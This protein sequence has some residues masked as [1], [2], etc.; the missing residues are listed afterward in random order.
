MS[1]AMARPDDTLEEP[2]EFEIDP[3]VQ[4]EL[5]KHPGKWVAMTRS[6]ILEVGESP[7]EVLQRARDRGFAAPIL[8]NVPESKTAVYFF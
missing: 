6:Q 4:K 8:Y 3:D 1:T 2:L 5:H 7:R